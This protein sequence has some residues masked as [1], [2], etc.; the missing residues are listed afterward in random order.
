MKNYIL[1]RFWSKVEKTDKCW[2]WNGCKHSRSGHGM[3]WTGEKNSNGNTIIRLAH[4]ISY[5]LEYGKISKGKQINHICIK[6]PHCINPKHLY[7]GTQKDNMRDKRGM[8]YTKYKGLTDEI[9]SI[10]VEDYCKGDYSIKD[11]SE[12]YDASYDVV[13]RI[14]KKLGRKKLTDNKQLKPYKDRRQKLTKEQVEQIRKFY[15]ESKIITQQKL[16]DIF[17]VSKMNINHI[18]RNKIWKN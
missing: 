11:L 16:A 2:L 1:D 8:S 17:G 9:A 3:F 15:S 6:T 13:R 12:K 10:M 18:L 5:E 14:L 7:E 4:R